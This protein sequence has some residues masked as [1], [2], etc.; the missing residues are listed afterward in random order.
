MDGYFEAEKLFIDFLLMSEADAYAGKFT[1]NIDR[2]AIMLMTARKNGMVPFISM[3]SIW[4]SDYGEGGG[5][6][7]GEW[8][9]KYGHTEFGC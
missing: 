2:I 5:K 4:C 9:K 6:L 3:D 1:S 8:T 7:V